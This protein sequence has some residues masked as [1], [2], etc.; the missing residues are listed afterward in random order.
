MVEFI[1]NPAGFRELQTN[2]TTGAGIAAG[3]ARDR[4]KQ[5]IRDEGRVDTG[6]L[7]QSVRAEEVSSN[8]D[9]STWRIGSD[10]EYAGYQ[11]DG[12]QGPI[13]PKRASVLRFKPKGSSTFVFAKSVSGFEGIF[14]ATRALEQVRPE[15]FRW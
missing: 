11:H 2:V 6:A 15:D 13:Y 4:A 1:P 3:K 8:K 7:L 5:I 9:G 12:V 10:L 14:F